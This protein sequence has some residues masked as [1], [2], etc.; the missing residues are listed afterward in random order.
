MSVCVCVGL[1]DWKKDK[2]T[3][4]ECEEKNQKKKEKKRKR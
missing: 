4:N 1:F 3:R 2:R